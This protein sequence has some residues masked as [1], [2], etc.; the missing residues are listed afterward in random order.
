MLVK[1]FVLA[2]V[3]DGVKSLK[4]FLFLPSYCW[5]LLNRKHLLNTMHGIHCTEVIAASFSSSFY[6]KQLFG[7]LVGSE[8]VKVNRILSHKITKS[9]CI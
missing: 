2:K 3:F 9:L 7:F 5:L 8:L 1:Y 4:L 6:A